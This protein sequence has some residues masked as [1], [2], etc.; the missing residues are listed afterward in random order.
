MSATRRSAELSHQAA[1]PPP[2]DEPAGSPADLDRLAAYFDS[3]DSGTLEWE[4]AEDVTIERPEM[5]QISLRLPK[6]DVAALRR[7]AGRAGIGY[8][9][10]IRMVVRHYLRTPLPQ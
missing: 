5:E 8:T 1:P 7:R 6:A 9:T 3:T 4:E 2:A 10:L